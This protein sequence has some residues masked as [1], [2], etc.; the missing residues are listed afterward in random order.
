MPDINW[1]GDETTAPFSS[2]LDE[3]AG[4]FIL[5]EDNDGSTVLL[6]WD[7]S[8]WQYRGPVEMN[9]ADISGV[10]TL[11]ATDATVSGTVDAGSVETEELTTGGIVNKSA[12]V[13]DRDPGVAQ[14]IFEIVLNLQYDGEVGFVDVL[15]ADGTASGG[16]EKWAF[17]QPLSDSSVS[18][19]NLHSTGSLNYSLDVQNSGYDQNLIISSSGGGGS[20]SVDIFIDVRYSRNFSINSLL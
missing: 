14:N 19:I 13:R 16:V 7:G 6:E 17:Y 11:T 3:T 10:G 20:G 5:A 18:V 2:R 4:N 12:Y 9:G 1:G 8:T 15:Y